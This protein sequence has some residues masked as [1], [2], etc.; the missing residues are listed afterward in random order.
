MIL[1]RAVLGGDLNL[2][3]GVAPVFRVIVVRDDFDFLD[4][5]LVRSDDGRPA[6][7]DAGGFDAVDLVVVFAGPSAACGD[8]AAVFD[9][10]HAIGTAGAADR[11][12]WQVIAAVYA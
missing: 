5:V 9:L 2:P 10:E 11:C 12:T 7:G 4:G 6:P 3:C 8:L 1:F